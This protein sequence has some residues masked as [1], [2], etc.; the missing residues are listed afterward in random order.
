MQKDPK[1][2]SAYEI[3]ELYEKKKEGDY[4][5]RR[6]LIESNIRMAMFM[7]NKYHNVGIEIQ[8]LVN[9]GVIGL[10]KGIDSYDTERGTPLAGYLWKCIE[11]EIRM[12]L[13]KHTRKNCNEV[14]LDEPIY[15]SD[16]EPKLTIL[17]KL[18]VNC[19]DEPF[20]EYFEK[21]RR[22]MIKQMI[23]ELPSQEQK[24]VL[25]RYGFINDERLTQKEVGENLGLARSSISRKQSKILKKLYKK[26]PKDDSNNFL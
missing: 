26:M 23:F 10:I 16:D 8:E 7:A 15:K 6:I 9:I 11:N 13:R 5:A 4:D 14:S 20:E 17:D 3:K 21:E 22:V 12:F 24:I 19:F 1:T 18:Y 2:L 25:M